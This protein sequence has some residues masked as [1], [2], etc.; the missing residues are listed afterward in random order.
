MENE[1]RIADIPVW[2]MT[3]EGKGGWVTLTRGREEQW[4]CSEQRPAWFS[5]LLPPRDLLY[6]PPPLTTTNQPPLVSLF[7]NFTL[8]HF[9]HSLLPPALFK[10]TSVHPLHASTGAVST[11]QH[12]H[13]PFFCLSISKVALLLARSVH[14][15]RVIVLLRCIFLIMFPKANMGPIQRICFGMG[16]LWWFG[17]I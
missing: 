13:L 15:Q 11:H 1:L 5:H 12:Q 16:P 3:D 17:W 10:P 9:Y 4:R 7:Q 8:S 6:Q 14:Q 2:Y